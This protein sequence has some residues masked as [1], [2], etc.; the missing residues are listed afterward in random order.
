MHSL[1]RLITLAATLLIAS[2]AAAQDVHV[3]VAANFTPVLKELGQAFEKETGNHLVVSTGSTGKL[4]AQIANGAPYDVLLAAD[5]THP[6]MLEQAGLA[7]PGAFVYAYGRLALWSAKANYVDAN[8]DIL[9]A[10]RYRRLAI[11]NPKTAPYGAAAL[12]VLRH[13]NVYDEARPR[14]IQGEDIGQTF[15]FVAT[16]NADVGFVA[17][18]QV[19]AK[20][21][22]GSSW[23]V[24]TDLYPPIAQG[25]VLL[26]RGAN[27][28]AAR[29]FIAYLKSPAA[30][31]VIERF[32]Y[33][34]AA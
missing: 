6:R 15:Q 21:D 25:A 28:E 27:N 7:Q 17:L 13:L 14:L 31:T 8:G 1:T 29:A 11:A 4:Y 12:A 16:G 23:L 24:P 19:K 9:K 5:D 26:K 33:G 32:G 20:H 10:G 22:A 2:T 34:V 30:R 3:A 18:S